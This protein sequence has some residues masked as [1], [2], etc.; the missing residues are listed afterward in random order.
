VEELAK[1]GVPATLFVVPTFVGRG[2]YWWDAMASG[3]GGGVDPVL[4]Q[5]ALGD[6]RGRDRDVRTWA[7]A[8]GLR[9]GPVPEWGLVASENELRAAVRHPGIKLA[10]HTWTHANLV[11][12]SPAERREELARPLQWLRERCS[13]VIPWVSYPYGLVSPAVEGE[14]AAAGYTAAVSLGRGWFAPARANPYAVP[15]LNIPSGLSANGFVVCTSGLYTPS[16]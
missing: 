13:S 11:A 4:R 2:P 15:R 14:A 6:L 16:S 10:S 5:R 3:E 12:L 7:E 9:L 8:Q 1:R